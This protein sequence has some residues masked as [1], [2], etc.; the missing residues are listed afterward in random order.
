MV[1]NVWEY[2]DQLRTPSPQAL[3]GFPKLKPPPRADEPWYM[4]RGQSCGEQLDDSVIYEAASV[5][6]RWKDIYIGFR[7]VKNP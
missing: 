3:K 4:I 6:A 2:V 7:C 5:P 1:G